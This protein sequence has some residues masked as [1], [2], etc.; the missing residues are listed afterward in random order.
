MHS[1]SPLEDKLENV[2]RGHGRNLRSVD[3]AADCLN[4]EATRISTRVFVSLVSKLDTE[5]APESSFIGFLEKDNF[6]WFFN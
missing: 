3:V 6:S 4:P 1:S 2:P 5:I